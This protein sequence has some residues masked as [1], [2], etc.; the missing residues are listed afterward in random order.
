MGPDKIF[1]WLNSVLNEGSVQFGPR[2]YCQTSGVF[3]STSP[4]PELANDFAFWREYE[5][6]SRMVQEHK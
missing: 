6:L 2:M 5:F 3:M 4:A 1:R